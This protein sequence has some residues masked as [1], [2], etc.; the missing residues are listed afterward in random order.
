MNKVI[1]INLGGNAYQL[2]EGGYDLLRAYLATAEARL[3]KNPDREEIL[4]DI[5]AAMAEKF[6]ALL[7][8]H[9][10]VVETKEVE[11][12][13]AEMGPIDADDG[14]TGAAG[15]GSAGPGRTTG[16]ENAGTPKR[17]Y[18]IYEGAVI[19][20]VCNGIGAYLSV[21]PTLVRLAFVLCT[22]FWGMGLIVYVIM[23]FVIPE[24]RSP[25]EKAA[26][27][28]L[29]STA[30][31][32]IRRAKEG[33]YEAIKNFQDRKTR[34][35]WR[36]WFH[37]GMRAN[38]WR[39]GGYPW[40]GCCAPPVPIG[41]PWM[42]FA[43]PFLSLLGGTVTVLWFCALIS[44][45]A[46]GTVFGAALPAD[47]PP[48]VAA[49]LLCVICGILGGSLKTARRVLWWASGPPA[50][51]S[52]WVCFTE[53]IIRFVV[54]AVLFL[55]AIHFFPELRAAVQA[56]PSVIHEARDDIQ[57]WWRPR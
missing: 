40:G 6:R 34:H 25:E 9:T 32:F 56:M 38:A 11:K 35:R 33:Y 46:N 1:T 54:V 50:Q 4:S 57:A 28:G 36:R 2:E 52:F 12:V 30:Q 27:S 47:I 31:E 15:P 22:I 8:S 5:E 42:G 20:G 21:D 16:A 29:P 49:L 17:L 14:A 51:V 44:L 13:L 23:A 37:R 48:W 10:T 19:S 18:R 43:V 24:A 26:A 39:W 3:G 41:P 53:G 7:S 45:L 55:L